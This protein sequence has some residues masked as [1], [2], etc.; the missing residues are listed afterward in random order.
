MSLTLGESLTLILARV[1]LNTNSTPFKDRARQYWNEGSVVLSGE[2]QW[3]WLFKEAT[4]TTTDGTRKYSLAADVGRPL[5]FRH[6]TDDA[7][8]KM[9][10]VQEADRADPDSDDE[11]SSRGVYIVG[12]N[13]STGAWEVDLVP[14]PDTSSETITYRYYAII[15]NKTSSDDGTDL[16]PTMPEDAQFAVIDYA[17]ARYK[18]EKGDSVGEKE[19]MDSYDKKVAAMKKIDGETDGN[20]SFRLPRR[21]AP[22]P[23]V[24]LDV[25]GTLG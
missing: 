25:T 8:I 5:S 24:I 16:L 6:T 1:G 19:E 9:I 20:E 15:A 12:K 17:T 7:L 18:G 23:Q 13:S 11:G 3:Q 14:T 10:N 4:L 21:D 2:R 22:F